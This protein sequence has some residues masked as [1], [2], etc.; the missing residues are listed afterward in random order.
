MADFVTLGLLVPC[1]D[2]LIH[3]GAWRFGHRKRRGQQVRRAF[4][5]LGQGEQPIGGDFQRRGA[6][7]NHM[8]IRQAR[9]GP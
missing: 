3:Q 7:A 9:A 4:G 6:R 2:L 5:A 8:G 1:E